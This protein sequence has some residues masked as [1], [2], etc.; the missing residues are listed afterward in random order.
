MTKIKPEV[1]HGVPQVTWRMFEKDYTDRHI[2]H[3]VIEKWAAECP[4][5]IA[6]VSA[7]T[8]RD[9]SWA[10]F[11]EAMDGIACKLLEM[12]VQKGDFVASSLPFFPEHV[13]VMFACFKIGAVFA[14][15]DMRLK[16]SEAE[17]CIDLIKAKVYFHLGKTDF[18]DFG[19]MS[20][21]VMDNCDSLKY[22]VQFSNPDDINEDNDQTKVISALEFALDAKELLRKVNSG[23]RKDLGEQLKKASEAIGERDGCLVIYTTGSTSGYPKPALLCHQG[24][25]AQALCSGIAYGFDNPDDAVL[26]NMPPSHVGGLTQQF[27]TTLYF[28]GKAVVLDM[29]KPD[30]SLDAIAKYKCAIIGQIPSLFNMEWRMPN[31]YNYNLKSL[32]VAIYGGQA[33]T[34]PFA[35]QMAKMA[36]KIATGFG[37]TE[38][39]GMA[40]F[41]SLNASIDDIIS[42]AG[43]TMPITPMTIREPMKDDNTAGAEKPAGQIGEICFSGPQVF[44]GY[45]NDP[46]NTKKT[47]TKDGWLYTGD[48][49]SYD[50][51]GLHISGRSKFMIK[52]KGYNVYPP[53]IEDF[54]VEKFKDQVEVAG[55]V[56]MPHDVFGEGVFLFVEKKAGKH[57]TPEEI[58][59]ACK[60]GLAAY[61]RPSAVVVMEPAQMPLT[62][63]EKTDYVL[64]KNIAAKE[65]E[66]LRAKGK[67][68]RGKAE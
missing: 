46:E 4:A 1:V 26:V 17:R 55:V 23:E 12:G 21:A 52:P 43:Y 16:P 10:Q 65:I 50:D 53:E 47:I 2:L 44:L 60:T 22:C 3:H 63:T 31:Y 15:L 68:D 9:Y 38:M 20:E 14:P 42:S 7:D 67:W 39:S 35:E 56:G 27:F 45:V 19:K 6:L 54:V 28:G 8:G 5:K 40:T 58:M 33:I 49:G 51:K 37:M 66:A 48:L 11:K 34:R 41:S 29:F 32:K 30:L 18:A 64:L 57:V 13:F 59:A 62:R 24:I 61:K 36:P 25:C